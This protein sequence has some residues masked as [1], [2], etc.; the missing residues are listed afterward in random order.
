MTLNTTATREK[1]D[2]EAPNFSFIID[3]DNNASKS[4]PVLDAKL[5]VISGSL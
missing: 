4:E 3:P 5:Q 1:H 2:K